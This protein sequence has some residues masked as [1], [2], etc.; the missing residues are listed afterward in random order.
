MSLS[1]LVH[2]AGY[3]MAAVST[4]ADFDSVKYVRKVGGEDLA[5]S[6]STIRLALPGGGLTELSTVFFKFIMEM[7][8]TAYTACVWVVSWFANFAMSMGWLEA[9][10]PP[11]DAIQGVLQDV[12]RGYGLYITM[13]MITAFI[14]VIWMARGRWAS[15]IVELFVALVI[16]N[17]AL[18]SVSSGATV[19]APYS[20]LNVMLGV[21]GDDNDG[22]DSDGDGEDHDS[23]PGLIYQS[24][25]FGTDIVGR[26]DGEMDN[27]RT[28]N[29]LTPAQ[30]IVES[31]L[32]YPVQL[33]NFGEVLVPREVENR[34]DPHYNDC[35]DAYA[36][37][38]AYIQRHGDKEN[39][40]G[41][42]LADAI[43]QHVPGEYGERAASAVG[44]DARY[45][46]E[47]W[48]VPGA[49]VYD[50]EER[51]E[52]QANLQGI[53]TQWFLG[54][55]VGFLGLVV[56]VIAGA[57]I[58]AG[59]NAVIQCFKL[60][61]ALLVAI[62]P[63]GARRSL[64]VTLGSAATS[65]LILVFSVIFLGTFLV[66]IQQLFATQS[67]SSFGQRIGTFMLIDALLVVG[68]IIFWRGRK[69][70]AQ[71][72]EKLA[73]AMSNMTAG[74]GGGG[75]GGF[76]KAANSGGLMAGMRGFH[77][78]MDVQRD[79]TGGRHLHS[80]MRR[81]GGG[82]FSGPGSVVMSAGSRGGPGGAAN[83]AR[84]TGGAM[85]RAGAV[86][87][88]KKLA[89]TAALGFVTGGSSLLVQGGAVAAKSGA[90]KAAGKGLAAAGR[91]ARWVGNRGMTGLHAI[92]N[93]WDRVNR[94]Q[95]VNRRRKLVNK[96]RWNDARLRW[97][98]ANTAAVDFAA[99]A[100]NGRLGTALKVEQR[101][102]ARA[103]KVKEFRNQYLEK[104]REL[105]DK[106][107]KA[108]ARM[109]PA[110]RQRHQAWRDR[111]V[112]KI[113]KKNARRRARERGGFG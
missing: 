19:L 87:G 110:Q 62:L 73:D 18:A 9:I 84:T 61:L 28:Y 69:S 44:D 81:R 113:N 41:G 98:D 109:T 33:V 64:W 51:F 36:L 89:G 94:G 106:D 70:V 24:R 25:D 88:A 76:G 7:M 55:S 32:W 57:V 14:C 66:I 11:F 31:F 105:I 21:D 34:D 20:P 40:K 74:G 58:L 30:S 15:G 71:S 60:L 85:V 10:R 92:R 68:V 16:V 38:L 67:G 49:C 50:D 93:D 79:I 101:G 78:A 65:L 27:E 48:K 22:V 12:L 96:K 1:G 29:A 35:M 103:D 112:T 47:A 8:W 75:A 2:A 42:D 86:K 102:E 43:R 59:V 53:L 17:Y 45:L 46:D 80:M 83:A 82:G 5:L 63:K 6:I 77:T 4:S 91:G 26:L 3:R 107:N 111:Q 56:L 90:F 13:L 99:R 104:K 39:G 95:G 72:K 100:T 23:T 54:P 52:N 97:H 37:V 108:Q